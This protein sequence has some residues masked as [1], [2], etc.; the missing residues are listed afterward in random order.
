[1]GVRLNMENNYEEKIARIV[2]EYAISDVYSTP[3]VAAYTYKKNEQEQRL[4]FIYK[5][6]NESLDIM[7]HHGRFFNQFF[8]ETNISLKAYALQ[9][10]FIKNNLHFV[11][12]EKMRIYYDRDGIFN[13]PKEKVLKKEYQKK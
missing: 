2:S 5:D 6:W 8:E 13:K 10:D 12:Q 9:A 4:Y 3:L 11:N 7:A 1:M